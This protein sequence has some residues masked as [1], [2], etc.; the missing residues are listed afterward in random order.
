ML[1]NRTREPGG[2]VISFGLTPADVN[3]KVYGFDGSE[4]TV[5]VEPPPH[6]ARRRH[7]TTARNTTASI[8]PTVA[9]TGGRQ[10]FARAGGTRTTG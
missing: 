6:D 5:G 10:R 8:I 9:V 1:T 2:T 7:S 4:G 3:V